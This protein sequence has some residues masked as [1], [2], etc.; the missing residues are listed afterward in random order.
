MGRRS[1][2]TG[3]PATAAPALHTIRHHAAI[4]KFGPASGSMYGVIEAKFYGPVDVAAFDTLRQA[5]FEVAGM[6]GIFVF[7]LDTALVM[8]SKHPAIP[9]GV[10]PSEYPAVAVVTAGGKDERMFWLNHSL[11]MSEAGFR[12]WSTFGAF[13]NED[14]R[15]NQTDRAYE[16]AEAVGRERSRQAAK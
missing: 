15:R 3:T 2:K 16:W 13:S 11:E 6:G 9:S 5:L 4:V 1:T 7:R 10:R 8:M 12:R 14:G